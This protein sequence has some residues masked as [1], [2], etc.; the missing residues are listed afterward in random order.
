MLYSRNKEVNKFAWISVTAYIHLFKVWFAGAKT[1]KRKSQIPRPSAAAWGSRLYEHRQLPADPN[2]S[3]CG[4][5]VSASSRVCSPSR[6]SEPTLRGWRRERGEFGTPSLRPAIGHRE[7]HR[8]R[9]S[10]VR[11][12]T[13][14]TVGHPLRNPRGVSVFLYVY[15]SVCLSGLRS[16]R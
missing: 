12:Q 9:M 8:R 13:L 4:R 15:F 11:Q 14:T 10:Y 7:A 5:A 1:K 16:A 6:A 2:L 3:A